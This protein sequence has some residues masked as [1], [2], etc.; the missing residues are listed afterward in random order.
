MAAHVSSPT[1]FQGC[2]F[3]LDETLLNTEHLLAQSITA[4]VKTLTQRETTV[5]M[6]DNMRGLPDHGPLSWTR[7]ILR[8]LECSTV[9]PEALFEET[10]GM[11][12]KCME[13]CD[14][15]PGVSSLVRELFD[16]GV[17]LSIATSSLRHHV[18]LKRKRH[19]SAL[20][21][22][23][24]PQHIVC[25][26]DVQPTPKP[27]PQPY[28]LAASLLKL[29]PSQCVAFEDSP[30]G[31][32]SAVAA[33]CFVVAIPSPG[34]VAKAREIVGRGRG[35]VLGSLEE[36]VGGKWKEV[37]HFTPMPSPSSS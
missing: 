28:L 15:M 9:S 20:F 16:L 5:E 13:A 31:I 1:P 26:E 32:T 2:I 6:L 18:A 19:E 3:D 30:T 29:H 37:I 14:L 21:Y 22:A 8:D 11:F 25:V 10:E 7:S 34:N 4:A 12:S 33:G 24:Q 35:V 27:H 17:P 23:F 36:W